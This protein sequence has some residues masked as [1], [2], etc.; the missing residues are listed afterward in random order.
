MTTDTATTTTYTPNLSGRLAF[1]HANSKG[2][3]AA[4]RFELKPAAERRPG[5]CFMELA[6]QKTTAGTREGDRKPAT[7]DWEHKA[8]VK[9]D[10]M[11]VCSVMGVIER[12]QGSLGNGKGLYHTNGTTNTVIGLRAN[13]ERPGFI[14]SISRKAGDGEQVFKGHIQLSEEEATG[15][16]AAL[17]GGLFYMAFGL[18]AHPVLDR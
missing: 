10:F 18:P 7:F 12:R 17:H 11:D 14:L 13:E 5:C 4:V 2:Q 3:G 9:L 1:Y 6:M 15:L 8:T 16:A